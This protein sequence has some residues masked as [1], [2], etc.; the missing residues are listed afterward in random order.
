VVAAPEA[1]ASEP[2]AS[3]FCTR[4]ARKN[5]GCIFKKN[6]DGKIAAPVSPPSWFDGR[7]LRVLLTTMR[8]S[9]EARD[10]SAREIF[11]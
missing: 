3:F 8:A 10:V 4:Q 1:D 7:T 9:I 6:D 11:L 5:V 2:R